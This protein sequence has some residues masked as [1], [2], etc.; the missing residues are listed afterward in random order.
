M[1]YEWKCKACGYSV[2]VDRKLSEY[3][4][5][6]EGEEAEHDCECREFRR[7]VTSPTRIFVHENE[8]A[9]W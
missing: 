4:R 6:P 7:I 9:Y 1:R 3:Q 2:D 5:P 8:D